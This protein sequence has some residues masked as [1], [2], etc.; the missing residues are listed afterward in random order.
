MGR[1]SIED[2]K[3]HFVYTKGAEQSD[4]FRVFGRMTDLNTAYASSELFPLFANRLLNK[5]RPEY[6]KYLQWLNI[7]EGQGNPFFI[8]S[9]TGGKR[10]TDSL[11]VFPCPE[12]NFLDQYDVSFFVHGIRYFPERSIERVKMLN[13]SERLYLVSDLQNEH[14]KNAIALRT[15]D[16]V[17]MIGYVPRFLA[18]DF[19]ELIDK[20][21][22]PMSLSVKVEKVNIDAPEQ[23][24]LLC[25]IT[26]PWPDSFRSCSTELFKPIVE[27]HS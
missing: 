14:D 5:S 11:E 17:E 21:E 1:L 4:R 13:L 26:A 25:K 12:P 15:K 23:L 20:L 6:G 22:D 2:D 9:L 19:N 10:S 7:S 3:Y 16:P 24:R 8:L 27:L 18:D